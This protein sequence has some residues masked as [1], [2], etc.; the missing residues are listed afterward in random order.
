MNIP[1]EVVRCVALSVSFFTPMKAQL[2]LALQRTH[3]VIDTH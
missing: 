3:Q 1:A 2:T